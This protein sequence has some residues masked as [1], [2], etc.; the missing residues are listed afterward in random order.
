MGRRSSTPQFQNPLVINPKVNFS[1]AFSRH[2]L[3]TGWEYQ[4]IDTD[5]LDFSPQYGQD[6]YGGQFSRPTGV[7]S[8]NL[9][10]VA[11]FLFG[12]RNS[13][14]LANDVTV[15]ILQRMNFFYVQ[16]DWKVN[17]KL[18]VN[19]GARYEYATPQW[20]AQNRLTSFDPT[21]Q[22]LI[23]AKSG[24]I[25]N[26][27]LV[28]PDRNNFAPRIGVAY[29]LTPKT[30]IRSGYGVSYIHF[31]RMGGENLLSYNLPQVISVSID[32]VPTNPLCAPNVGNINCFRPT[33]M[34]YP[35]GMVAPGR[36]DTVVNRTNYT[37]VDNRTGYVQS[38]HFSIQQELAHSL[39][40]EVAYVGNRGVG[41]LVLG[42]Y[43]QARPNLTGQNLSVQA[44]RPLQTFGDIQ[45]S[46]GGGFSKY[47]GLQLKIERRFHAGLY[48]LNSFSWS[49]SIDNA[50]GHLETANGD[51]SRVNFRNIQAD[52]GT[53]SYNQPI[54]NTTTLVYDMPYGK[55]RKFGATAPGVLQAVL[56]GWR[57]TL[58][59]TMTSGQP[60]NLTYGATTQF[61][62]GYPTMR[63]NVTG[64]LYP[65][66]GAQ[67]FSNFFERANIAA[68]TDPSQPF[69]GAS[70]N[71]AR[72]Y[73]LYSTDLGLHKAFPLW[74]EG[75]QIEFRAEAF[76]LLNKTNFGLPNSDRAN[77]A[78]GRIT[79][80]FPARVVQLALKLVF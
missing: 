32:Q 48:L 27:A 12:A 8:N 28:H 42:D 69:G 13:Y 30:V 70:R 1:K 23:F 39:V 26:R 61:S 9:F 17:R 35:T 60:I 41:L 54:N 38:W 56:G 75:K 44:R 46:W 5:V 10:N 18:T 67:S 45:Q 57:T 31:N 2:T 72:G 51:N 37:P 3:K 68:P 78:F 76:N 43:N 25:S 6:N 64:P 59:N 80:T 11:D 52:R 4:K 29:S 63:P 14:Q 53:G 40:M 36:L 7:S 15:E 74:K 62:V 20:E 33:A 79:S 71:M 49:H 55:G 19:L 58:I 34:G 50:A 77:A 22:S 73:P 16:D 21:T 65:S 47:D 24:S 66:G